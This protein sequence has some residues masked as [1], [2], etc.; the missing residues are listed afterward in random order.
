MLGLETEARDNLGLRLDDT[1][2]DK[3]KVWKENWVGWQ[4]NVQNVSLGLGNIF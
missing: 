2:L 3:F 1:G 4:D